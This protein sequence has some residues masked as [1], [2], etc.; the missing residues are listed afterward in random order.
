MKMFFKANAL[1]AKKYMSLCRY[2]S[3]MTVKLAADGDVK[4]ALISFKLASHLLILAEKLLR[5]ESGKAP[6]PDKPSNNLKR[7]HSI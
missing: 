2:A 6:S 1:S 4:A 5:V 3:N 7:R